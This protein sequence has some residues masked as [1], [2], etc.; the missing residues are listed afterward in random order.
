MIK[1]CGRTRYG[2]AIPSSV[3]SKPA[4]NQPPPHLTC[5]SG[6]INSV[7]A[8]S[9]YVFDDQ[10]AQLVARDLAVVIGVK[11]LEDFR[12][13]SDAVFTDQVFHQVDEF[14]A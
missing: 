9:E 4:P 10:L 1:A 11:L 12:A 13:H 5:E 14:T 6:L 8:N 3:T 7:G 2:K